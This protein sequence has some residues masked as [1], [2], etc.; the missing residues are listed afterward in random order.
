MTHIQPLETRTL[1]CAAM[2]DT[3]LGAP[4]TAAAALHERVAPSP[5]ATYSGRW[6][7]AVNG[8]HATM[9][10]VIS[11]YKASTGAITGKVYVLIDGDTVTRML[12]A[13]GKLTLA[14][15]KFT[16]ALKGTFGTGTVA[17]TFT[18]TFSKVT[19]TYSASEPVGGK[20]HGTYSLT[21]K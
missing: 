20:D 6:T 10:L 4:L 8:T 17:G 1:F 9:R 12:N 5:I 21:R 3:T 7:S 14:T 19:G 13:T 15:H 2:A 18:T 11:S 16:V